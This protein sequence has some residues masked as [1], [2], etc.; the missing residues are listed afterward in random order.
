MLRYDTSMAATRW[1]P[2]PG[3]S[4]I[5][6]S[7]RDA[8]SF[9]QGQLTS[10]LLGIDRHP[11]LL[12]A[13]CNRQGRVLA[14]LRLAAHGESVRVMLPRALAPALVAHLSQFVLRAEVRFESS[15]SAVA[16]LLDAAPALEARAAAAGL[17]V[18]VASPER[19]LLLGESDRIAELLH[20]VARTGV[21][22]WEAACIADGEPMVYADTSGLWVPQMLNLDLV[23][24]ISFQKGCYLGQEIVARAQH[25]GRIRRRMLRYAGPGDAAPAA[26]APLYLGPAPVA[27]VVRSAAAGRL[28]CLAVVALDQCGEL[29][30]VAP[31]GSELV[32]ADLPYAIPAA[33]FEA[34]EQPA[35]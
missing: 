9:L 34:E 17:T 11:G 18:M 35:G 12:A 22:D 23:H 16:G 1:T 24:A 27:Q 30:G 31:G 28:E 19:A 3:M 7:G 2:L 6:A 32:P 14:L 21:G 29:L 26:G 13:A 20:D 25:L 33:A 5:A 8:R 4:V 15:A 10:D